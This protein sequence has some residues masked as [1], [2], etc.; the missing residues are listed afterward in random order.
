MK[1]FVFFTGIVL[2]FLFLLAFPAE[3]L[4]A[5]RQ[6]LNL[7]LNTLLPTLLPFLILTGLLLGTDGIERMLS[8][9]KKVWNI[10]F[11]LSSSGAYALLLG[12]LCGYPMGAKVTSDLYT[13]GQI[14]KREAEYLLTFCNNASPAFIATYLSHICL[15]GQVPLREILTILIL[16]DLA[17]MLFFRFVIFGGQ[18]I[19]DTSGNPSK[20]ETS[21]LRSQGTLIDVSIMN[22]FET[23]TRLGGY[24]LLFTLVSACIRHFLELPP[25]VCCSLSGILEISSGLNEIANTALSI[26][27]KYFLSMIATSF[28]GLCILAQTRSVLNRTLSVKPY[29]AAKLINAAL[30]ALLVSVFL[31]V[32]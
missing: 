22:G 21:R 30:T 14:T 27:M 32:I 5:A 8:P 16:S 3:A 11:G 13:D 15:A 2:L 28:G 20:K 24:I 9:L 6:G 18:T 17:C 29:I 25:V 26:H 10:L 4:S 12:L 19:S 23:I 7:W 31:K 1:R